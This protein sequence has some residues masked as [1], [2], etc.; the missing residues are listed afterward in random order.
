MFQKTFI[1]LFFKLVKIRAIFVLKSSGED[2]L[3]QSLLKTHTKDTDGL[4][5]KQITIGK[6]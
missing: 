2:D 4:C 6:G 1:K 3:S 5:V